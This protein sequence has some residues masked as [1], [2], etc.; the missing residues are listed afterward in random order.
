MRQPPQNAPTDQTANFFWILI[1][2]VIAGVVLWLLEK[3]KI[4]TILFHIRYYE[5]VAI[6][7][8]ATLINVAAASVHLP[9]LNLNSLTYWE[10]YMA[11]TTWKEVTFQDVELLSN[12][13]GLWLRFPVMAVMGILGGWLLFRHNTA[14]FQNVYTMKTLKMVEAVNWPQIAP[15]LKLDLVK[16]NLD[17]GSWAMAQTPLDF[18]KKYDLI[19]AID[20]KNNK[21]KWVVRKARAHRVFALQLGPF[22]RNLQQLPIY[23]QA[24]IVI[25][26]AKAEREHDI[27]HRLVDQISGSANSGKLDFTGVVSQLVKY[28][29]SRIVRFLLPRHGYVTTFMASL[30]EIARSDGVLATSEF[31]WLKPLDRRLW[32]MLNTVGRQT[33]VIEV[34][35]AYAHWLAEKRYACA[36][37]VPTVKEAVIALE[38]CVADILY[39]DARDRWQALED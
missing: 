32:Y 3:E 4:I 12:S 21:K 29:N 26:I 7:W 33:A 16:E 22:W 36:L 17:T 13:I 19:K 1:M 31:L 14:R 5:I 6:R 9:L 11:T 30:L 18:C 27:A 23:V 15:I 25:F 37:R 20:D 28:Q 8:C 38:N 24:L 35:G 34:A 39:I 10:H 2:L